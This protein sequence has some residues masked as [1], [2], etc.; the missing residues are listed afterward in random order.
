MSIIFFNY[1][2]FN[3]LLICFCMNLDT[4]GKWWPRGRRGEARRG[5]GV[6]APGGEGRGEPC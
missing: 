2:N 6:Q 4:P 3:K 1:L 5:L